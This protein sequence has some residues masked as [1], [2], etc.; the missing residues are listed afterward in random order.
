MRLFVFASVMKEFRSWAQA[1]LSRS[2][3]GHLKAEWEWFCLFACFLKN[4]HKTE[5]VTYKTSFLFK[6][7]VLHNMHNA[8]KFTVSILSVF[9]V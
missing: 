1:V 7:F 2:F 4:E 6:N 8:I 9:Q 3:Y 5:N